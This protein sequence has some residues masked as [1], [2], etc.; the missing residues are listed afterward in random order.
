MSAPILVAPRVL[1]GQSVQPEPAP[2]GS[3]EE[4]LPRSYEGEFYPV[5]RPPAENK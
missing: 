2:A 1:V 5:V 3:A 4:G